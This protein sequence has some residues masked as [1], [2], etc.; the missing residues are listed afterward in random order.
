MCTLV[1][2][3]DDFIF[4]KP[5]L[6]HKGVGLSPQG[7]LECEDPFNGMITDELIKDGVTSVVVNGAKDTDAM[8]ALKS[9]NKRVCLTMQVDKGEGTTYT[10]NKC[11]YCNI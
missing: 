9:V 6:D 3:T 5:L 2:K 11:T 8:T 1:N 10:I 7:S 4:F